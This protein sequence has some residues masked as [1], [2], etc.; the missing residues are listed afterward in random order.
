MK[1]LKNENMVV[2]DTKIYQ[3]IKK[4]KLVEY[5]TKHHK[6]GKNALL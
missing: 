4:Q 5:R 6:M 2:T 3:K 1:K